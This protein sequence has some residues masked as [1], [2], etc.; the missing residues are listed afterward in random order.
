M[1]GLER[2]ENDESTPTSRYMSFSMW[3]LDQN[4]LLYYARD[5]LHCLLAAVDEPLSAYAPRI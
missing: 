4:P 1:D 5:Q 3:V 2:H